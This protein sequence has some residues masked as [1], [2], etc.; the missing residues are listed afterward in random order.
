MRLC[1]LARGV[2]AAVLQEQHGVR[3]SARGDLGVDGALQIPRRLV[4]E[5]V[6]AQSQV[7]EPGAMALSL[8]SYG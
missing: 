2:D 1:S 8:M 3:S 4:V 7:N 6:T 5:M